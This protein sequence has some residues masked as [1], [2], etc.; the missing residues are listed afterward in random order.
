MSKDHESAPSD[1]EQR[2]IIALDKLNIDYIFQYVIF[3]GGTVRGGIII[4]FLISPFDIPVEVF[5]DY[6]HESEFN[7]ED[8]MRLSRIE[9]YFG[10]EV[11]IFWGHE[12]LTQEDADRI[13]KEKLG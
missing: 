9:E 4:D 2:V 13:V 12:L 11:I 8:R 5:G 1:L 6:Y 3:G 7:S 10:R